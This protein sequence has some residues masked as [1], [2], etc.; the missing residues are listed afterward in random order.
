MFIVWLKLKMTKFSFNA[1]VTFDM[2]AVW[3]SYSLLLLFTS[4]R[5]VSLHCAQRSYYRVRIHCS[6]DQ[7]KAVTKHWMNNWIVY[8]SIPVIIDSLCSYETLNLF[9]MSIHIMVWKPTR[10]LSAIMPDFEMTFI[11][12]IDRVC[13]WTTLFKTM[14]INIELL[15]WQPLL[16]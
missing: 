5:G 12:H 1:F 6:S 13:P 7:D 9:M 11:S 8:C 3:I 10:N 15:L 16:F 2:C 4:V 14:G